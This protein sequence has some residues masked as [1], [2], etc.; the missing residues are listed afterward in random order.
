[1]GAPEHEERCPRCGTPYSPSQEYCLECGAK[2]PTRSG[3]VALL[4]SA[5]R[6]RL[7]WYP[8]DW[9]WPSLLALMVA[10]AAGAGD[11]RNDGD[12]PRP[13]PTAAL[14]ED[15]RAV[16]RGPQR[17]DRRARLAPQRERQGPRA[18]RGAAGAPPRNE[19]GRRPRLVAV[20]ESPSRLFRRLRG[21]LRQPGRRAERHH[22][23]P[24]EGL[25][26]RVPE[27]HHALRLS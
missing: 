27:A 20:L 6:K 17:V 22:R 13:A 5:W 1:M 7:G 9:I 16:A 10:A 19:E 25:R 4:G 23:R 15:A 14:D 8:G 12:R 2:L 24:P 3:V 18:R 21:H 11:Q 26:R